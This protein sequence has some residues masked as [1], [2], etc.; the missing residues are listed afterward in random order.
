MKTRKPKR[1][2]I[3]TAK[4][5]HIRTGGMTMLELDI[6][7]RKDMNQFTMYD[8]VVKFLKK[9]NDRKNFSII[10]LGFAEQ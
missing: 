10:Y 9:S 4:L 7:T 3:I 8:I 2:I 1:H 6:H 5:Q